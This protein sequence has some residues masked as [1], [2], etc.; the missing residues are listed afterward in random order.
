M[1]HQGLD[2]CVFTIDSDKEPQVIPASSSQS[3]LNSTG[4]QS[5]LT[6][7]Q[8]NFRFTNLEN[9]EEGRIPTPTSMVS[10]L[11]FLRNFL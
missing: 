9:E 7:S 8:T 4:S 2:N 1:H 10:C 11:L 6:S 5:I 3:D